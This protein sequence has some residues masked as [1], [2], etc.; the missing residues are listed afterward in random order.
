MFIEFKVGDGS[1]TA[2]VRA[3]KVIWVCGGQVMVDDGTETPFTLAAG[4]DE[5]RIVRGA[6]AALAGRSVLGSDVD[7]DRADLERQ[8]LAGLRRLNAGPPPALA[9]TRLLTAAE[10]AELT[11]RLREWQEDPGRYVAPRVS[12]DGQDGVTRAA[13][14]AIKLTDGS[15]GPAP[16]VAAVKPEGEWAGVPTVWESAVVPLTPPLVT[17][18]FH[19]VHRNSWGDP[20]AGTGP[21]NPS[22]L[23]RQEE[24]DACGKPVTDAYRTR[25]C[26]RPAHHAGDCE[27]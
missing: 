26:V 14:G 16:R 23:A 1:R 17:E 9:T 2:R 8:F 22:E 21:R 18:G 27:P 13:A 11:A 7:V 12:H 20:A 5:G 15:R 6:T 19:A 3:D 24:S 25:P 10:Q 4:E